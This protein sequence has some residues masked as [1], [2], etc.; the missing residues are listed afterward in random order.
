MR[1][2]PRSL[3]G[4]LLV[5]DPSGRSE[6][7]RSTVV[8]G[9]PYHALMPP[10]PSLKLAWTTTDSANKR[11]MRRAAGVRTG[12]PCAVVRAPRQPPSPRACG[13]RPPRTPP[14]P[15]PSAP[16]RRPPSRRPPPWP[17][18]PARAA[19][20]SPRATAAAACAR[21]GASVMRVAGSAGVQM[22]R[23]EG[24]RE[25]GG[26]DPR[27]RARAVVPEDAALAPGVAIAGRVLG[28]HLED[29]GEPLQLQPV[30][31]GVVGV[32][33][34]GRAG[35]KAVRS[36]GGVAGRERRRDGAGHERTHG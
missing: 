4:C 34:P 26:F 1:H 14:S 13:R 36:A 30:L 21:E 10:S 18:P 32:E 12:E 5:C 9:W 6:S 7:T 31:V 24:E 23:A 25:R 3:Y 11:A 33:L 35:A 19:P 17:P 2:Q 15:P 20:A 29:G 28:I 8:S 22:R 27:V 16:P